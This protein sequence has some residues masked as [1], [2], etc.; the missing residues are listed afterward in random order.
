MLTLLCNSDKRICLR[1]FVVDDLGEV[2][3]DI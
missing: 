1:M 3:E 2:R